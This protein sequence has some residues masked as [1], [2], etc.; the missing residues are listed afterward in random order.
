MH[1]ILFVV[2]FLTFFFLWL[3]EMETVEVDGKV[4]TRRRT[5]WL[6]SWIVFLCILIIFGVVMWQHKRVLTFCEDMIYQPGAARDNVAKWECHDK[7]RWSLNLEDAWNSKMHSSH[8][9]LGI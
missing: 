3:F 1:I 7:L 4:E 9:Q 2:L 6:I 8:K 5:G